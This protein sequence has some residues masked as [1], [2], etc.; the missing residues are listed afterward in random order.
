MRV[1]LRVP[2]L[3]ESVKTATIAR[4]LKQAGDTVLL[5]EPVVELD[6]DKA[7]LEVPAPATGVLDAHLAPVGAEVA[8]GQVITAVIEGNVQRSSVPV[9]IGRAHV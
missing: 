8:V 1:E 5:D 6:S 9:K 7:S 4:W 2:S 3:G